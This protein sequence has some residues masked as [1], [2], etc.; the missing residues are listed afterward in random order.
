MYELPTAI[1]PPVLDILVIFVT[2]KNTSDNYLRSE[3]LSSPVV[4]EVFDIINPIDDINIDLNISKE[5]DI[6]CLNS[7]I[8]TSSKI[9]CHKHFLLFFIPYIIWVFKKLQRP[10]NITIYELFQLQV[11]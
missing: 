4:L 8:L 6:H 11:F 2:F 1:N 5:Q 10:S 3:Q 7:S 9:L